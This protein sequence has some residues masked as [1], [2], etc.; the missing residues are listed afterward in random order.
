[1]CDTTDCAA[2]PLVVTVFGIDAIAVPS[3]DVAA[4]LGAVG[5]PSQSCVVVPTEP[6]LVSPV[7]VTDFGIDATGVPSADVP[8]NPVSVKDTL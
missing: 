8:A 4:R 1:M 5:L 7:R 6:V 2:T 3:A